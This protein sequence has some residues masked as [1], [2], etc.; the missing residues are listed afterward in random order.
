[1][2]PKPT[3]ENP[4]EPPAAKTFWFKCPCEEEKCHLGIFAIVPGE[5]ETP[6]ELNKV[7]KEFNLGH[8]IKE[9]DPIKAAKIFLN[10]DHDK[11]VALLSKYFRGKLGVYMVPPMFYAQVPE[12][13]RYSDFNVKKHVDGIKG[14]KAESQMFH[15]LKQYFEKTGDDVLIIHSHKFFHKDTKTNKQTTNEKDFIIVNVTKGNHCFFP[16]CF[17]LIL[18]SKQNGC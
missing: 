11:L 6:T 5:A 7:Q 4:K 16:K 2:D 15:A 18:M 13:V 3:D 12:A 14:D 10:R 9:T 8:G 17:F 1:M